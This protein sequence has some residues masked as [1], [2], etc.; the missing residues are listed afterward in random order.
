VNGSYAE[1]I[2]AAAM[3]PGDKPTMTGPVAGMEGPPAATGL[4]AMPTGDATNDPGAAAADAIHALTAL[5]TH[6]P[7][8]QNQVDGM[9]AAVQAMAK[10]KPPAP[11]GGG[12]GPPGAGLGGPPAAGGA[13]PIMPPPV[14]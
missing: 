13:G 2:K 11:E 9:I 5:K 7:A 3:S 8:A 4:G 6:F 10:P 1:A 12:D 14:G